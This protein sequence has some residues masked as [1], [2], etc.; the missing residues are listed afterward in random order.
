MLQ[1]IN[2]R[3]AMFVFTELVLMLGVV[4]FDI[5]ALFMLI[6]IGSALLIGFIM[7]F[8]NLSNG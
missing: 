8:Y 2:K 6:P 3:I 1:R 7:F 4:F 5:S